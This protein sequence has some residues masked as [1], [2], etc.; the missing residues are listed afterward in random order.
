MNAMIFTF[1]G[2]FSKRRLP[3]AAS[4]FGYCMFKDLTL[5]HAAF[6]SDMKNLFV[7]LVVNCLIETNILFSPLAQFDPIVSLLYITCIMSLNYFNGGRKW[8]MISD[9]SLFRF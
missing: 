1:P 4:V 8:Y 6:L 9:F 5:A 3:H 2:C 7:W